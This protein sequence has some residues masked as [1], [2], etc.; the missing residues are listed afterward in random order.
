MPVSSKILFVFYSVQIQWQNRENLELAWVEERK[1]RPGARLTDWLADWLT[2]WWVEMFVLYVI[3]YLLFLYVCMFSCHFQCEEHT[4]TNEFVVVE[5]K[6]LN[7][8][9]FLFL[10]CFAFFLFWDL[11]IF[12][13]W[14]F[15]SFHTRGCGGVCNNFRVS[16]WTFFFQIV[17]VSSPS[18]FIFSSSSSYLPTPSTFLFAYIA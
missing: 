7:Y 5:F 4:M 8:L 3:F 12:S 6:C 9:L 13:G 14:I 2:D 1:T 18:I 17:F 10:L 16:F 11:H 15:G